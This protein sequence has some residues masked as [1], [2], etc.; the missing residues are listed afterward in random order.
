MSG[1]LRVI[2]DRLPDVTGGRLIEV[3]DA[4][5][6]SITAGE[7]R[8]RADGYA[9]LVITELPPAGGEPAQP[10]LQDHVRIFHAECGGI[11][12]GP[13]DN[14]TCAECG[15]AMTAF[16]TAAEEIELNACRQTKIA[17][18]LDNGGERP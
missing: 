5:G 13:L 8:L 2:F 7:W 16:I 18:R 6:K 17:Q 12:I 9:E 3:E 15:Q 14:L 1:E 11:V 4:S 10:R